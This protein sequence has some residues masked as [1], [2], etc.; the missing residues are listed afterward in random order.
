[1]S[2]VGWA[3]G[4]WQRRALTGSSAQ[5]SAPVPFRVERVATIAAPAADALRVLVDPA[6]TPAIEG[7]DTF[8]VLVPGRPVGAVGERRCFVRPVGA[9]AALSGSLQEVVEV[10]PGRRWASVDLSGSMRLRRSVTAEPVSPDTCLL[11]VAIEGVGPDGVAR[12][13]EGALGPLLDHDLTA[14]AHL[15]A[16]WPPP[17]PPEPNAMLRRIR[18]QDEQALWRLVRAP[19][20]TVRAHDVVRTSAAPVRAWLAVADARND[21]WDD[22]DPDAVSFTVPGTPP[23]QVGE[24]RCRVHHGST[25]IDGHIAEVMA[26]DPGEAIVVRERGL[27]AAVRTTWVA[28]DG[29]GTRITREVVVDSPTPEAT[30]LRLAEDLRRW[31]EAL[32]RHL[33]A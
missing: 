11:R 22:P 15:V 28:P 14:A 30:R 5:A 26:V 4:R 13:L 10:D 18:A 3:Q 25:G 23:G 2:V 29:A 19:R 33:G 9:G 1:M 17:P 32:V 12:H 8:T 31:R 21:C 27:V 16:G 7:P 24:L 6:S 20:E